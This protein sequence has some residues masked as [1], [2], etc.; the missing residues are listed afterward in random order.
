M[1][2]PGSGGFYGQIRHR[3]LLFL[4]YLAGT[5]SANWLGRLAD[6]RSRRSLLLTAVAMMLGGVLLTL[7]SYLPTVLIGTGLVT[8]GFFGAHATTSGWV[9]AHATHRRAQAS[10]LYLLFYHLG[11]S[12]LGFAGGLAYGVGGWNGLVLLVT[13]AAGV[14]LLAARG[15]PQLVMPT[16]R[17]T[18]GSEP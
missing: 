3:H 10:S 11:S 2:R 6:R 13:V 9:G 5:V 4:L 17:D 16:T 14:A 12:L 15:L 18:V 8:F 1:Y 7:P